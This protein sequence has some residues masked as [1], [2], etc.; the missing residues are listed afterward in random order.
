MR[1]LSTA[2]L[3]L[4]A[5]SALAND[6]LKTQQVIVQPLDTM[7]AC[8]LKND[9]YSE[10]MVVTMG[11]VTMQCMRKKASNGFRSDGQSLEWVKLD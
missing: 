3:I 11:A 6:G 7:Q 10:G 1:L 2:L 5:T 8:Y 9:V 4:S